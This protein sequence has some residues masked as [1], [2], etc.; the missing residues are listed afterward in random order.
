[1][2]TKQISNEQLVE[3]WFK[4]KYATNWHQ[5]QGVHPYADPFLKKFL[6]EIWLPAVRG[7]NQ[8]RRI[9][10]LQDARLTVWRLNQFYKLYANQ[11]WVNL[12]WNPESSNYG[13]TD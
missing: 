4:G 5:G 9:G 1:M 8:H 13:R 7:P 10:G 6:L 12:P 3:N 2:K 11:T